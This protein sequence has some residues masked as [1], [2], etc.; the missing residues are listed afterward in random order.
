MLYDEKNKYEL[1]DMNTE[2]HAV[3]ESTENS[4]IDHTKEEE[5]QG[6]SFFDHVIHF[7][8][9]K[10]HVACQQNQL[11]SFCQ[12]CTGQDSL[13]MVMAQDI[14]VMNSSQFHAEAS[15]GHVCEGSTYYVEGST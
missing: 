1:L 3:V 14:L 10:Y 12:S 9:W 7:K 4:H 2:G 13:L 5:F 6:H 15:W 8:R 11:A